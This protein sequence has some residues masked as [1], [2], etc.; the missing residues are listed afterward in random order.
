MRLPIC[1][2]V[3]VTLVIASASASRAAARDRLGVLIASEADQRLGDNLTEVA[4]AQAAEE[5]GDELVGARELRAT[6]AQM[7]NIAQVDKTADLA[8]CAEDLG[9]VVEVARA[10]GLARVLVGTVHASGAGSRVRLTLVDATTGKETAPL[11]Q[12][13]ATDTAALIAAVQSGVRRLLAP[14][15]P[16]ETSVPGAPPVSSP[17]AAPLVSTVDAHAITA[18]ADDR[19]RTSHGRARLVVAYGAGGLA[20]ASFA[21]AIVTGVIATGDPTGVMRIEAQQDLDRRKQYAR[22]A[23]GCWIAGGVLSIAS[24]AAFVWRW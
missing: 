10:G 9:C 24:A 8:T 2:A 16:S 12:D 23:N 11:V 6:I 14:A 4:I 3:A 15:G 17:A 13:V 20:L 18:A 21:T 22:V 19:A 7:G 5:V 1:A